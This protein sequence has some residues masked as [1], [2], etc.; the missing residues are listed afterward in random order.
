M[1]ILTGERYVNNLKQHYLNINKM[2]TQRKIFIVNLALPRKKRNQEKTSVNTFNNNQPFPIKKNGSGK[3]MSE[4]KKASKEDYND[5]K[6][7]EKDK[8]K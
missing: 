6:P 7:I 5:E 1:D 4:F 8:L 2:L 3:G